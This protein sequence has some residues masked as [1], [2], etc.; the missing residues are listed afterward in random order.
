[1]IV[2]ELSGVSI[3]VDEGN[4][5]Y[6]G[7]FSLQNH[8]D[9]ALF[10][11][12]KPF[13]FDMMGEAYS[14]VVDSKTF[15]KQEVTSGVEYRVTLNCLSPSVKLISP[16]A[17]TI[18]KTWPTTT[19]RTVVEEVLAG[20]PMS[21]G[22]LDWPLPNKLFSVTEQAPLDIVKTLVSAVGAVVESLPDG[23]LN[24]RY[25]FP[26]SVPTYG[27]ST[28]NHYFSEAEEAISGRE[29]FTSNRVLNRFRVMNSQSA[30]GADRMEFKETDPGSGA[31]QVYVYP[32]PWRTTFTLSTTRLGVS[33]G[34]QQYNE[35]EE[36]ET[37][38][39]VSGKG[40]VRYSV[41]SIVGTDFLDTDLTGVSFTQG[42]SEVVTTNPTDLYSL[43]KITYKVRSLVYNVMGSPGL[44]AQFLMEE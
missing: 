43:L 44:E 12:D 40:N 4:L 32:S 30:Q 33:I 2:V 14:F 20:Y 41:L 5:F 27:P 38:E 34:P 11:I 3:S 18:T 10:P 19:A 7:T 31:G 15:E 35:R 9:S 29:G 28:V 8:L 17:N 6:S 24:V 23:S 25:K 42:S 37:I 39:I 21:W 1:M 16:R 26:I 13:V 22:I 36:V